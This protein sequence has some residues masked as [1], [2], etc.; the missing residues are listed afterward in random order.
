MKYIVLSGI[1]QMALRNL[2]QNKI[3]TIEIRSPHNF[4]SALETDA[5][6]VIFLTTT[7][8]EDVWTGTTGIIAKILEKQ[9]SMHRIVHQTDELF[10]EAE[11][12]MARLKLEL[13]GHARVRRSICCKMGEAVVVDADEVQFFEGR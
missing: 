2:E 7:S 4:L 5:G 1:S 11:V 12:Q 10:E 9:V 13:K 3:K 8:M 6:D